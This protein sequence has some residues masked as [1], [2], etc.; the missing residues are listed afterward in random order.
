[1]KPCLFGSLALTAAVCMFCGCVKREKNVAIIGS[2]TLKLSKIRSLMPDTLDDSAK[3]R[4]MVLRYSL[5]HQA[6]ARTPQADSAAKKLSQRLT[7]LS[8]HEWSPEA[9]AVLLSAGAA[10]ETKIGATRDPHHCAAVIESLAT[11]CG[12]T[13]EGKTTGRAIDA[14]DIAKLDTS[15]RTDAALFALVFKISEEE[16]ATLLNF[17]KKG[18]KEEKTDAA[19]LVKGLLSPPEGASASPAVGAATVA[20]ERV[21]VE[22]PAL[23]LRFRS[24]E[25]IHDSIAKHRADLQQLYKKQ[26]KT[27]E[28]AGGVVW[29][30]FHVGPDGKV[31]SVAVKS[32]AI[33]NGAFLQQLQE[34]ARTIRFKTIP[35]DVGNMTFEFPF[36]FTPES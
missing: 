8:G 6:P 33:G 20:A 10:L 21:E 12:T 27:N 22:N 15:H 9:A 31:L 11:L 1:M 35:K 4:Q 32:S 18:S 16:A 14:R 36:E 24:Q 3:I 28:A 26:L 13:P 30:V 23:A 7:L 19:A 29:L 5:A 34:Y 2:D 25:S 17:V